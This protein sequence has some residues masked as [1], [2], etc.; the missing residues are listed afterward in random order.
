MLSLSEPEVESDKSEG[1]DAAF[2]L[3][4]LTIEPTVGILAAGLAS[5]A[6]LLDI[7]GTGFTFSSSSSASL[8]DVVDDE[9]DE[10]ILLFLLL[11]FFPFG[12]PFI[13]TSE[14]PNP[15]VLASLSSSL[16]LLAACF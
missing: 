5:F 10:R 11:S 12:A 2:R 15:S 16:P 9:A 4:F 6:A 13:S 14:L 7:V 1:V 3:R 8:S